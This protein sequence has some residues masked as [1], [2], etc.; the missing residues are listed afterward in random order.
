MD[1]RII[2][3][4]DI[5]A[6][7]LIKPINLEGVRVVGDPKVY[8]ERYY[9]QGI[10]EI[11]YI[12]AV[13]TLYGRNNLE[14]LVRETAEGMFVP[15]TVGGGIKTLADVERMLR[16]GADKVAINTAAINNPTIISE[17]ANRFGSQCMVLSVEAKA[18]GMNK[19]E[20]YTDNGRNKTGMDVIAWVQQALELGAGEILLTSVDKEGMRLGYDLPLIKAVAQIAT[21]PVIASGGM[22]NVQHA[23]HALQQGA[24]AIAIAHLLHYAEISVAD[25]RQG[26][27]V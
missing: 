20:A 16:A 22:G 26:I 18:C 4:L 9:H 23:I 3:R 21:V 14:Q 19:W 2:A 11:L 8:A 10:D 27:A 7:N 13:A 6:P 5:K 15:M 24:D 25:V 1:A 12:D 17:V